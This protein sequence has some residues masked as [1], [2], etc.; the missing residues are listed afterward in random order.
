MH[1]HLPNI[2]STSRI[3]ASLI[4]LII[5]SDFG[6]PAYIALVTLVATS[7]L[8]DWADGYLARKWK[9]TST[10]GYVLD[11]MGDRAIHLA[12]TLV[13]M[14]RHQINPVL[15]WLLIFR[16]I[17][18]YGIRVLAADWLPRSKKIQ[19]ISRTHA[20]I[21][22]IWLTS[23]F[24]SDGLRIFKNVDLEMLPAYSIAQDFIL[25]TTIILSYW[26]LG[27][28]IMWLQD[29]NSKAFGAEDLDA[30][31]QESP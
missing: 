25:A 18:I 17:A 28:A 15:I 4:I 30:K 11:A 22:R 2:L 10:T 26:G 12:L 20:T 8:T 16:D 14:V 5:A 6:L 19:W 9:I 1:R 29:D 27:R 21:L 7:M 23:Y 24:L 3:A 31:A 13:V